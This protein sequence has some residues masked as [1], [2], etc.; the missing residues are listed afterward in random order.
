VCLGL[1]EKGSRRRRQAVEDRLMACWAFFDAV[2]AR[3]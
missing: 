2:A 3:T 1:R